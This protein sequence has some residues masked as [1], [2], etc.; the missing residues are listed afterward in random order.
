MDDREN[1]PPIP[2]VVS[3]DTPPPIGPHAP[4]LAP[5]AGYSDI[6]F[7][8]LCREFGAA[9]AVTEMVSAKGLVYRSQGSEVL[10][11]TNTADNPLVVQLFGSEPEYVERAMDIL[12]EAG[13]RW[14]D[15]NSGCPVP[16]VIKTGCGS[17]MMKDPEH[18]WKITE[19]MTRKAGKNAVGVKFRLG[20]EK[21]NDVFLDV[22]KGLEQAGAAWLT[23]HSRYARQGYGGTARWEALA[24]LRR[25]VSVPIMASGDLFSAQ[26][27]ARCMRETAAR[28]GMS[29]SDIPADGVPDSG[30]MKDIGL[31]F[32]RGAL[33]NPMIFSDY[34]A[35]CEGR[36]LPQWSGQKLVACIRRHI[37]LARELTNEYNAL[38]KMRTFVPRY[39]KRLSG[40]K[41]LR[42]RLIRCTSW[43]ELDGLLEE[44]SRMEAAPA[45]S[46]ATQAMEIGT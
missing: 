35:L 9:V 27:A 41:D 21:G 10:L 1:L 5:L 4:W 20:F 15:L 14:F 16:K 18:L 29:D 8:Q 37:A 38:L 46:E 13:Y 44:A 24:E 19:I 43:D 42:R 33:T 23:L 2:K 40:A 34:K 22:A 26:D 3:S 12:L 36:E 17:A 45:G 6:A 32:A 39:V 25:A 7:R 30:P 11:T 31:M 28:L